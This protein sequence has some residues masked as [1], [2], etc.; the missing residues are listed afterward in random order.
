MARSR[1]FTSPRRS[2]TRR[3]TSWSIGA[4]GLLSLSADGSSVFPEA[5]SSAVDG[6]TLIRTRGE[7]VLEISSIASALDG[8][9]EIAAGLCIVSENAAGIGATALPAPIADQ[10]WDGWFWYWTGS[11]IG[12]V[13]G[14]FGVNGGQSVRIPIDSKAMRKLRATDVVV[15]MLELDDEVGTAIL[16]A[17]LNTRTL[18][19]L[20]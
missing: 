4:R 5:L 9:N 18:F 19:K 15:G 3:L 8:W 11:C 13:S 17:R 7:L 2:N 14:N 10:A 6:L 16:Q 20:P 12:T 1:G